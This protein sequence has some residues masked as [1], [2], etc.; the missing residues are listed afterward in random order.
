MGRPDRENERPQCVDFL[1]VRPAVCSGRGCTPGSGVRA[2]STSTPAAPSWA[3]YVASSRE[4]TGWAKAELLAAP[5]WRSPA[6]S[7]AAGTAT[8]E[9]GLAALAQNPTLEGIY[10]IFCFL[11]TDLQG[12]G[13]WRTSFS[14]QTLKASAPGR[15]PE[16]IGTDLFFKFLHSNPEVMISSTQDCP[17]SRQGGRKGRSSKGPSSHPH[18]NGN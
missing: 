7:G 14:H 13:C 17:F 8:S 9:L 2:K 11:P 16:F 3:G 15:G 6:R 12:K 5:G 18:I 1:S 10:C 4:V